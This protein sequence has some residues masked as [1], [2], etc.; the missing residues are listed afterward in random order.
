[1]RVIEHVDRRVSLGSDL[2]KATVRRMEAK[3]ESSVKDTMVQM[4]CSLRLRG[5]EQ[6]GGKVEARWDSNAYVTT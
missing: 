1:M 5:E 3:R 6:G 2:L 4:Q